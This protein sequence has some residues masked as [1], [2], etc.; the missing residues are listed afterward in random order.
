MLSSNSSSAVRGDGSIVVANEPDVTTMS[1]NMPS[2]DSFRVRDACLEMLFVNPS[3]VPSASF[4]LTL[5]PLRISLACMEDSP[6]E[7]LAWFECLVG[8]GIVDLL[9]VLATDERATIAHHAL[10]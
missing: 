4:V 10:R 5:I 1:R 8:E 7:V 6:C 3:V 9:V 2:H